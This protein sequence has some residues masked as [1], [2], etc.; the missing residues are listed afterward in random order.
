MYSPKR[1]PCSLFHGTRVF[2]F[3]DPFND[4]VDRNAQVDWLMLY[5]Y[6]RTSQ[7]PTNSEVSGP[8]MS[9]LVNQI[10]LKINFTFG[11]GSVGMHCDV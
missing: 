5:A 8:A 6:A 4:P 3:S 7:W 10:T 11:N 2:S 1:K 9:A